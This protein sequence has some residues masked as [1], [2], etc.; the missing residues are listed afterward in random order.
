MDQNIKGIGKMICL[1]EMEH[2]KCQM[3][4]IYLDNGKMGKLMEKLYLSLIMG[5][6]IKECL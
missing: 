4:I 1:M 3:E 5:I 2:S 6:L